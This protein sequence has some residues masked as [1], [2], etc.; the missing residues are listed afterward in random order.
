M[1]S[2]K[3]SRTYSVFDN[4]TRPDVLDIDKKE[5]EAKRKRAM[6]KL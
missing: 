1:S 5:G 6:D 2:S 3:K 4:A